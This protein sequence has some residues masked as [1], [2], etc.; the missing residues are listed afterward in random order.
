ME[1]RTESDGEDCMEAPVK[2]DEE[3]EEE[4][5]EEEGKVGGGTGVGTEEACSPL[6]AALRGVTSSTSN[7]LAR[8]SKSRASS[9]NDASLEGE[10][11]ISI[12]CSYSVHTVGRAVREPK[13]RDKMG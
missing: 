5:E 13:G 3:E 6:F 8:I 1:D 4:E 2:A 10:G 12:L 9:L 7:L 11:S